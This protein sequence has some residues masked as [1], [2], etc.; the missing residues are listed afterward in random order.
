M[1]KD[2]LPTA[3]IMDSGPAGNDI[4]VPNSSMLA[5]QLLALTRSAGLDFFLVTT[6]PQADKPEFAA[7]L[8]VSN[9]PTALRE[10]YA[11][12]DIFATS[13][14]I[15]QLKKQV[16]PH[17]FRHCPFVSAKPSA[18][19]AGLGTA[20]EG[21]GLGGSVVFSLHDRR[22]NHYVFAFSGER[23]AVETSEMW[24]LLMACME[25]LDTSFEP[26]RVKEEP[27]DRLSARELE[28]LRWSAAGKSSEEIAIILD[29][30]THTVVSYLKCAMRKLNSVNRMQAVARAC[31]FRLL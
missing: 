9:W 24:T 20:F 23:L 6:F 27:H 26:L 31:R 7:N 8:V 19:V 12:T 15:L 1:Y 16:Q 2:S 17:F 30:S 25:L 14:L 22:L 10:A 28:C 13:P 4:V 21:V 5:L 11:G 29:I 3:E 18:A